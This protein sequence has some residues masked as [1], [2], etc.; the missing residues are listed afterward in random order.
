MTLDQLRIFLCVAELQHVTRAAERLN[1]TQSAVSAAISSF[2]RQNDVILFHRS[3][4]GITLTENGKTLMAAARTLLAEAETTK[5]LIQDL[6][7]NMRGHLR[8]H[9]SQTVANYWLPPYLTQMHEKHSGVSI[10][11][12]VRNSEEVVAAVRAG[13]ADIG[14]VESEADVIGLK[15]QMVARDELVLVGARDNP[16]LRKSEITAGDYLSMR[17]IM[18][19]EG[20]GTRGIFARHLMDMGLATEDLHVVLELPSNEAIL[21]AIR[22]SQNVAMLS[23]RSIG[24]ARFR[25]LAIRRAMPET[26]PRRAFSMMTDP[27]R[28]VTRAAQAFISLFQGHDPEA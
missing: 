28:H 13:A 16:A 12:T 7:R 18:R 27:R 21:A 22:Q 6:S 11:L 25:G 20:S 14:F 23:W 24:P 26:R 5:L 2:E 10:S 4:R 1:L 17:W 15:R 3:G 8:I 9:A 19:E